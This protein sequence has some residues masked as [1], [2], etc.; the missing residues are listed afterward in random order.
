MDEER[1]MVEKEMHDEFIERVMSYVPEG[2]L[3]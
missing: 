3:C 2:S 1:R